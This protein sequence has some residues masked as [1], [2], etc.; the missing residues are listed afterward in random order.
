MWHPQY[1]VY[2]FREVLGPCKISKIIIQWPIFQIHRPL[3]EKILIEPFICQQLNVEPEQ[4]NI[5]FL[6]N[7]IFTLGSQL[8]TS[9]VANVQFF[10][11][12]KAM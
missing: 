11:E 5:S 6:H 10:D 3:L 8:Q 4:H 2:S 1:S 9:K 12:E 7:I